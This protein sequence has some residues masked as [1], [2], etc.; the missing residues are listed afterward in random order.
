MF[1]YVFQGAWGVLISTSAGGWDTDE[2]GGGEEGKWQTEER[3]RA[4]GREKQTDGD[5]ITQTVLLIKIHFL[6]WFTVHEISS[7]LY[8]TR[9]VFVR[10]CFCGELDIFHTN[11]GV[12]LISD[13]ELMFGFRVEVELLENVQ[14]TERKTLHLMEIH[15]LKVRRQ[16]LVHLNYC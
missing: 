9:K 8:N 6:K 10:L 16:G 12:E 3:E 11:T 4:T 14:L 1:L 7:S 2:R 5:R 15:V 13:I